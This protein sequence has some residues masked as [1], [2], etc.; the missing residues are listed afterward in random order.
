MRL[1]TAQQAGELELMPC[2]TA[3]KEPAARMLLDG[4]A[5]A[6]QGSVPL[7]QAPRP[8]AVIPAAPAALDELPAPT[9]RPPTYV[10]AARPH[11]SVTWSAEQAADV[12]SASQQQQQQQAVVESLSQLVAAAAAV[13]PPTARARPAAA[14]ATPDAADQRR[15]AAVRDA[16]EYQHV[17]VPPSTHDQVEDFLQRFPDVARRD[18]YKLRAEFDAFDVQQKVRRE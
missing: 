3:R 1:R 12:V 2:Q 17:W 11:A 7:Q 10:S 18:A 5:G 9:A 13:A 4:R 6:R 16:I 15:R 14:G 8:M